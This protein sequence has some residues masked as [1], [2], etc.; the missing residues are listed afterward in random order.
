[1]DKKPKKPRK[2]PDRR[3]RIT[4]SNEWIQRGPLVPWMHKY[5]CWLAE[6]P[7][8]MLSL[9]GSEGNR[10]RGRPYVSERAIKCTMFAGRRILRQYVTALEQREDVVE[11]FNRLRSDAQFKA[12]E[13]AIQTIT[14]NLEAREAGLAKALDEE[15]KGEG[16]DPA[17]VER[18]TRPVIDWALPKVR[19]AA[20]QPKAPVITINLLGN[21]DAQKLLGRVLAET[22]ADDLPLDYEII[23]TKEL[24]SG[25]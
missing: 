22:D 16:M 15:H 6:Q 14:R 12:R 5:I 24:E 20:E 25:E 17:L 19:D 2:P 11:Y 23:E 9:R 13:L 21:L 18:F 7:E 1:M 10:K 3:P 4:T 8:A